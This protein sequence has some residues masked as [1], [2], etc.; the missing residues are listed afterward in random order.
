MINPKRIICDFLGWI[1]IPTEILDNK[2]KKL[3]HIS[4][5]PV[6]IFP[7]IKKLINT[8]KP[9]YI[10]HTGD[11]VD[12]LK[13]E[14]YPQKINEYSYHVRKLI[15]ILENSSAEKIIITLG[16]HDH[17]GIVED[18][19]K[20]SVV[21]EY[22]YLTKISGNSFHMSHYAQDIIENPAD[23]NLFGH[24]LSIRTSEMDNKIYL[25]GI[26]NINIIALNSMKIFYSPYPW[27]TDDLRLCKGR[28]KL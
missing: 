2:E 4:D 8:L 19:A 11:M 23:Y 14:I 1:Y 13:I 26:S 3:L 17:K 21:A 15:R 10:I 25:N 18:F 22:E 16:N 12:N 9:E 7:G 6:H 20:R 27:G 28:I 24:D 5:T